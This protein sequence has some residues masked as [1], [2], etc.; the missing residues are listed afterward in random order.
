MTT[1]V[2]R[3]RLRNATAMFPFSGSCPVTSNDTAGWQG[4]GLRQLTRPAT[5]N[6]RATQAHFT[7]DGR[8]IYT[9]V[10]SGSRTLWLIHADGSNGAPIPASGG[11]I[12]THGDW[13]PTES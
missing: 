9:R 12:R 5:S 3:R 13:Q 11:W 7:P 2:Q 8:I 10:T 6:N 4:R 1:S